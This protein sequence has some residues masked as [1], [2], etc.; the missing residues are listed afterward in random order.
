MIHRGDIYSTDQELILLEEMGLKLSPDVVVLVM[1]DNDFLA[2]TEDFVYRRYYKPYFELDVGG[3]LVPRNNPVPL[4]TRAQRVK[5][6]L[7]QEVNLW[8]LA[9]SRESVYGPVN[10]FLGQ[11]QVGVSR[12]PTDD[13][14]ELT[15][16][17]V[18]AVAERVDAAGAR[19]LVIN[20]A[21]AARRPL[22]ITR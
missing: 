21:I 19:L 17:L 1:C 12:S 15:A 4:L 10:S 20:T 9:R 22:S 2:N 11:L 6:F 5:L 7:G 16:V 13:P 18:R 14:V 3:G 8:N